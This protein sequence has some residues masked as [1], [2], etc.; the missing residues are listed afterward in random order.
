MLETMK[1]ENT[2]EGVTL[3]KYITISSSLNR[4]H[5]HLLGHIDQR[6]RCLS[7]KGMKC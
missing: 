4:K 1:I 5:H 2:N 6:D 3:E 7:Q